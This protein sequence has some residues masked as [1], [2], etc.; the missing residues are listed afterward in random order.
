MFIKSSTRKFTN[1]NKWTQTACTCKIPFKPTKPE[2]TLIEHP[3]L[4]MLPNYHTQPMDDLEIEDPSCDS[5]E[6]HDSEDE[7]NLPPP[8]PFFDRRVR[9]T[10]SAPKIMQKMLSRAILSSPTRGG[11]KGRDILQARPMAT[12]MLN[13]YS[14]RSTHNRGIGYSVLTSVMECGGKQWRRGQ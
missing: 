11:T 7:S 10:A 3:L 9:A 6:Y 2:T 14:S 1:Q 8:L 13:L 4:G 5:T 12:S